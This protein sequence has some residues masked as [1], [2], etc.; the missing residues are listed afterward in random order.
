MEPGMPGMFMGRPGWPPPG[1][2]GGGTPAVVGRD[3]SKAG[4][5]EPLL[6]VMGM[7]GAGMGGGACE[8]GAAEECRGTTLDAMSEEGVAALKAGVKAWGGAV[9]EVWDHLD[10]LVRPGDSLGSE[11][12]A[13]G[14]PGSAV[15]VFWELYLTRVPLVVVTHGERLPSLPAAFIASTFLL[16]STRWARNGKRTLDPR[17]RAVAPLMEA[18]D[19]GA[20]RAEDEAVFAA[21]VLVVGDVIAC[22]AWGECFRL[23]GWRQAVGGSSTGLAGLDARRGRAG[24]AASGGWV[25]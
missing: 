9:E 20:Q 11:D 17:E 8:L 19:V 23:A 10:A 15:E 18:T 16:A 22:I 25:K 2:G 1:A 12:D 24:G 6:L 14:N 3:D 5:T 7:A 4:R 21:G 13:L